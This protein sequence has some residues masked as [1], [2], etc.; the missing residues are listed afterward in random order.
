VGNLQIVF[1]VF[2]FYKL[3]LCKSRKGKTFR[4]T[5]TNFHTTSVLMP[6]YHEHPQQKCWNIYCHEFHKLLML[7]NP[8]IFL[9]FECSLI[10]KNLVIL[11]SFK[12]LHAYDIYKIKFYVTSLLTILSSF[13][14]ELPLEPSL[15]RTLMEA[16]ENGC[17][18][19]ALTVAA[20]LS[21]ETTLL[22]GQRL[23]CIYALGGPFW[24]FQSCYYFKSC[25]LFWN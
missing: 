1:F 13:D 23:V 14:S 7:A 16:N 8:S 20:M 24:L 4:T 10:S 25:L 5:N 11:S 17:L 19:Q 3:Q 15:S 21:A 9:D 6:N 12:I 18:S 2:F 22:A